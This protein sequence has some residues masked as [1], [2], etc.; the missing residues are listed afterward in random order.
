MGRWLASIIVCGAVTLSYA[1]VLERAVRKPGAGPYYRIHRGKLWGFMDDKG[2]TV[3]APQFEEV[4]D[5]FAGRARVRKDRLWGYI[6]ERGRLAIPFQFYRSGDFIEGLAPVQSGRRGWGLI[7]PTGRFVVQPHFGAI[8]EFSDGLA[9]FEDWDQIQCA[10]ASGYVTYTKANASEQEF[11]LHDGSNDDMGF[12]ACVGGRFGFL[13]HDGRTAI[14]PRFQLAWDFSDGRAAFREGD[15]LRETDKDGYVDKS[16]TVVVAP[17]FASA[18]PFSEG[19]AAVTVTFSPPNR[20]GVIDK[21]GKFVVAPDF[22]SIG[23]FSEG[24]AT[25]CPENQHC[26]FIDR[27]GKFLVPPRFT[28]AQPFSEGVSLAWS[29]DVLGPYY[30][31]HTGKI[32]L[33]LGWTAWPFSGGL[34]VMIIGDRY[35]YV[36]HVGKVIGTYETL[37]PQR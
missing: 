4:G 14:Q 6:D 16:G 1:S 19:L 29:D 35:A 12:I 7:D 21:D 30:V 2:K 10:E 26:G 11:Y 23:S 18:G 33:K 15:T 9:R 27:S 28:S 32:V 37:K 31:D 17:Q 22:W 8:A 3:I 20:S 34:T 5:F 36:D 25:A 13:D 24:R